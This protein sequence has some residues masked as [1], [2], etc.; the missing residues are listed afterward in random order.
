MASYLFTF[1]GRV[2]ASQ[3]WTIGIRANY[4]GPTGQPTGAALSAACAQL[5]TDFT[6]AAWATSASGTTNLASVAGSAS[7][8]DIV[9][10]YWYDAGTGPAVVAGVGQGTAQPGTGSSNLPPQCAIVATLLTGLAGRSARG[11]VYIPN[12]TVIVDASGN[13]PTATA[14]GIAT[15]MANFL[16]LMRTRSV[17]TSLLVPVVQG[18]NQV[19]PITAVAVDTI[20]DTQRRRRDKVVAVARPTVNLI[21]G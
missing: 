20:V 16:S 9:R 3:R 10:G 2:A 6:N 12:R 7:T 5:Y 14:S 8:F 21:V 15:S 13:F 17:G 4:T 11:R 18:R 19:N 1:G